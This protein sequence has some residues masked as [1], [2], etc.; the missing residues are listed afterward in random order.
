MGF[1]KDVKSVTSSTMGVL[2]EGAS[3]L[4]EGADVMHYSAIKLSLE[5]QIINR[6][7]SL[8]LA[9]SQVDSSVDL[10]EE[11]RELELVINR[12]I[13]HSPEE[14]SELERKKEYY[15][16]LLRGASLAEARK[17]ANDNR[18]TIESTIYDAP[19]AEQT[20]LKDYL[21][22][23]RLVRSL[24][25]SSVDKEKVQN[26]IVRIENRVNEL[27]DKR[28]SQDR[29]LYSSGE[30]KYLVNLKDGRLLGRVIFWHKSGQVKYEM[31]FSD[32]GYIASMNAYDC[33]GNHV[34][35][36]VGEFFD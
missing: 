20:D 26:E 11:Y 12:L 1:W 13:K 32:G 25:K 16:E 34:L 21:I 2:S 27:E 3:A 23:L 9:Y 35:E 28:Y 19:C 15:S 29:I 6:C 14:K 24:Y 30:N 36:Y 31:N 33:Q 4:A 10:K 22:K 8:D 18:L 7:R 17:R 5:L